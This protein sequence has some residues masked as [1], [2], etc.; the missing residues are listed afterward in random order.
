MMTTFMANGLARNGYLALPASGTGRGVLVLH[1]WWGLTD[2]FKT[3]CVRLAAE[4]FVAFAPDLYQGQTAATID[5]TKQLNQMMEENNFPEM[6]AT[7]DAA[8]HFLQTHPAVQGDKVGAVGFSMGAYFAL[9]LDEGHAESLAGIVLFYGVG[10]AD[11]SSRKAQF[12]G[13]YAENDEWE[14]LEQVK[15][16]TAVNAEIHIYPNTGHWF[17]ESNKPEHYQ[18]AAA[19]LAWQRTVAFLNKT[20]PIGER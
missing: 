14:P 10:G 15:G 17:F 18:P 2:F 20:L 1:A 16:M 11:L 6:K 4:G 5:E 9:L 12:Q 7:A 3:T 19:T 8:L 13:H